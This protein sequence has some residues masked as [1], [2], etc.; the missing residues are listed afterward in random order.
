MEPKPARSGRKKKERSGDVYS[1]GEEGEGSR[2]PP[3][4]KRYN[5]HD[6]LFFRMGSGGLDSQVMSVGIIMCHMCYRARARATCMI[7]LVS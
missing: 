6:R 2:Q 3:R 5:M 4:K 1:D 7:T